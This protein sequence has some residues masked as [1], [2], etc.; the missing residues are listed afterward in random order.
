MSG[1]QPKTPTPPVFIWGAPIV[2]VFA[3]AIFLVAIVIAYFTK[4]QTLLTVLLTAASVNATTVIGYWV[5]SSSGS[6]KK[7]DVIAAAKLNIG[8]QTHD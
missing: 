1:N 8:Q 6:A 2:S 3:L 7:D 5:G 4:E